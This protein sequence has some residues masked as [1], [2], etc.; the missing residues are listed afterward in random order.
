MRTNSIFFVSALDPLTNIPL[1]NKNQ[2]L[3]EVLDKALAPIA[4]VIVKQ[5]NCC[6]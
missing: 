1:T 5:P 4:N 3:V 2:E 6:E